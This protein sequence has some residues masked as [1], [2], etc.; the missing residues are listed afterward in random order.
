VRLGKCEVVDS[1]G[2]KNPRLA[3][4][5]ADKASKLKQ[6]LSK[7]SVDEN[8]GPM[9]ESDLLRLSTILDQR[10]VELARPHGTITA[11]GEELV[12]A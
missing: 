12:M 8:T 9:P 7:F 6:L 5:I 3:V 11:K 4:S 1:R 2:A 10:C